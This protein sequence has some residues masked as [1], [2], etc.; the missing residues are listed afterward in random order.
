[1][2]SLG[3]KR[4]RSPIE[5]IV[6]DECLGTASP[7]LAQLM[8]QIGNEPI[9]IVHLA[10]RHPGIPDIELLNKV[11][12]G[13][14]AL[15]TR[16]RV[17][18][19]VAIGR[20]LR[21]FIASPT[22]SLSDQKVPGVPGKLRPQPVPSGGLRESYLP[23]PNAEVQAIASCLTGFLSEQQL[24][25]FRTRRRRIRAHFGSLDNIAATAITVGQMRTGRGFVGGCQ[26]KIDA[27][28]GVTSLSP[29][30]ESYFLDCSP[31]QE[32]LHC[33]VWALVQLFVLQLQSLPATLFVC[34]AV[35]FRQ[36]ADLV[37]GHAV[38]NSQTAQATDRLL[39]AI[40][41]A[42]VQDCVKGRFFDRMTV[43]L[44]Q[45]AAGDS[46]ELVP[47]NIEAITTAVARIP[48]N[49]NKL[50]PGITI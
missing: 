6:V 18:H 16:D 35:L 2:S 36:C 37:G 24:R 15:L 44:H 4:V 40:C 9:E 48:A 29:A 7:L 42:R 5:R 28:H 20:G 45:L 30:S 1:M 27:R 12:D 13:R 46:N 22:G 49:P 50:H 8:H 25:K 3:R 38:G 39:R 23:K 10:A 26:L 41:K 33:V 17:L 43:K 21:S 34:D 11:L 32:L 31:H 19:N 14:T 47:I